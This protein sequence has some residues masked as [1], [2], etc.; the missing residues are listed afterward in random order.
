MNSSIKI[1]L[2][3]GVTSGVITTLGLMVG[4]YGS[5]DSK[6]AILGGIITIAIADA[7]SDSLGIHVSEESVEKSQDKVWR[8]TFFTF[9]SKFFT[10]LIFILPFL[11]LSIDFAIIFNVLIGFLILGIFSFLIAKSQKE[12]PL[13]VILEHVLIAFGV[14]IVTYFVGKGIGILFN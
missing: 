10:A 14:I 13:K 4:L 3:F 7:F 11:F 8:S 12:N 9:I 2:G 5:T 6:L 1:G